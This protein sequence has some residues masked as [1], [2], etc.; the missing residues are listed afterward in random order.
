MSEEAHSDASRT[1][2]IIFFVCFV[3]TMAIG[4]FAIFTYNAN[5]PEAKPSGGGHGGMIL[6]MDGQY[7]PHARVYP[8]A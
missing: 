3:I 6:P 2:L 5:A 4:G 1:W 8:V 7:A